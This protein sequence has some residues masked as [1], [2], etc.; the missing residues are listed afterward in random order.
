[1]AITEPITLA[2]AK[3]HLRVEHDADDAYISALITAARQ[4]CE[5]FQNRFLA[6]RGDDSEFDVPDRVELQAMLLLI[7]HWYAN[8]ESVSGKAMAEVPLCAHDL[9][10][11]RRRVPV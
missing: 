11:L 5:E 10:W 8:R 6:D 3:A 2:E 1:M 7:G 9:L 4:Y